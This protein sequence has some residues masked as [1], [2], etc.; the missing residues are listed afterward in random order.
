MSRYEIGDE[1]F[2]YNPDIHPCGLLGRVVSIDG[3]FAV[4]ELLW[5]IRGHNV[6]R[7]RVASLRPTPD[8]QKSWDTAKEKPGL[9]APSA[10]VRS[11]AQALRKTH[12]QYIK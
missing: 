6:V 3:G 12:P 10:D 8:L 4:V 7:C 11:L 5:A 2:A 9:P 1:V